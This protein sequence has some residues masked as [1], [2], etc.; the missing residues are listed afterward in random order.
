MRRRTRQRW[1]QGDEEAWLPRNSCAIDWSEIASSYIQSISKSTSVVYKC[2]SM[3]GLER[4]KD[5]AS[6]NSNESTGTN[7]AATARAVLL[8]AL[9][10][11]GSGCS[12]SVEKSPPLRGQG[13]STPTTLSI[14]AKSVLSPT[15]E[16]N[17]T[18]VG[19]RTVVLEFEPGAT[20][21][22][23]LST[24]PVDNPALE[25]PG[26]RDLNASAQPES[27]PS[28]QI[29]DYKNKDVPK[30]NAALATALPARRAGSESPSSQK[31]SGQS[32]DT[33]MDVLAFVGAV[34]A[35]AVVVA[36]F[37]RV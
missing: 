7:L 6:I 5:P 35:G 14:S 24:D 27:S 32:E 21:D 36:L 3:R 4:S 9:L 8:C 12:T 28:G 13:E 20:R 1:K 23:T 31:S 34:A 15:N 25:L 26:S 16:P 37:R 33:S 17:A 30:S 29:L 2:A 10:F 18:T 22:E 11:L 19:T